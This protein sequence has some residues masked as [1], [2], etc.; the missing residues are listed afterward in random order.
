MKRLAAIA[1][2]LTIAI[3]VPSS[4]HAFGGCEENCLKC[5]KLTPA[6]AE[7]VLQPV[8]PDVKVDD[9][10]IAPAKGLW[11]ISLT[12][13]GKKGIAYVDFSLQNI[14]VGRIVNIKSK[15]DLTRERMMEI[16]RVDVSQIELSNALVM[17]DPGARHR[18]IVFDDPD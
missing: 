2:F 1:I 5:H 14:I 6:D 3:A 8:L 4:V 11:E 15:V 12:S 9:V 7:K 18:V 10:R 13:R 16:R 17:G